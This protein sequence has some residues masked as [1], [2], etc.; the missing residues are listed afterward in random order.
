MSLL[1]TDIHRPLQT[2]PQTAQ[3]N[4]TTEMIIY[5]PIILISPCDLCN[6]RAHRF[7]DFILPI[8]NI[9]VHSAFDVKTRPLLSVAIKKNFS[10]LKN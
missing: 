1:T 8:L 6:S 3:S 10:G 9:P 7:T 4:F 2:K 5:L